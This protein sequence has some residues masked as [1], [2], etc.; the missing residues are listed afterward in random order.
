LTPWVG[1]GHLSLTLKASAL[2]TIEPPRFSGLMP[3]DLM[4]YRGSLGL[5]HRADIGRTTLV[6][7]ESAAAVFGDTTLLQE[8]VYFGGPTSLPGYFLHE[9][10]GKYGSSTRLELQIPVPAVSIPL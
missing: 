3:A 5:E 10:A 8:A 9:I 1:P 6:L 7:R 4:S 2:R